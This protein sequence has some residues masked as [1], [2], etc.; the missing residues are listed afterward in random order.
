M[1]D[2]SKVARKITIVLFAEQ[3]LASAAFIAASTLNGIVAADL[4]GSSG[5]AGVPAATYLLAGALAAFGWGILNDT[6]GRRRAL[7]LGLAIGAVGS[8]V[9]FFAISARS[10]GIFLGGML[11]MGIAN[12]AVQLA[13]FI[14]AEVNLPAARG[15]AISLVVLGGTV[16]SVVGPLVAGPAGAYFKAFAGSE[17]AGAYA[18]S[19]LLFVL[20]ALA[21]FLGLTPDP[22]KIGQALTA[23]IAADALLSGQVPVE[24]AKEARTA[25]EIF[26]QPE[27]VVALTSMLVGQLVMV[28]VMVITSLHM[29]DHQHALH[30]I[31]IV[32]ASHTFGMYVFSVFSGQLADRW[33]RK[34]VI[35][36]GAAT[37]VL[38][39]VAA[40]LSPDVVPLGV[41]LFFL[42]LG[43]N[44]CYVGGSTLLADQLTP[45]ERARTQGLNDLMVG[46]ASATGSLSSGLIFS[47]LGYSVMAYVSAGLALVPL[48]VA[49]M[50]Y[51]RP[52]NQAAAVS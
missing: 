15:R 31:S 7:V 14:A 42:G 33:G 4:A 3:G 18:I 46:L 47:A 50:L 20:G 29:K 51:R 6:M 13:R 16:G 40:T 49:S 34:P 5:W 27:S 37:L 12:S 24:R 8:A 9:A 32:I 35:I 11:L 41:A 21:I 26:A 39:C 45:R 43:W 52:V 1:A 10:F 28:M 30:D 17:L 48:L 38:A 19:S 25:R 36:V 23:S 22:R 44:F 2:F